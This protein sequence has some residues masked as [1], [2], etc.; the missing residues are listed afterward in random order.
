MRKLVVAEYVTLDGVMQDPGGVGEIEQGGWHNPYWNDELAGFQRDG[1]FASD[2]L[3][4]GRITYEGFAAAWPS[5]TD[6]EGF[7]DQMNGLPK[8][9]VSTTLE[10]ADWNNSRLITGNVADEVAKLKEQPG[11]DILV[12]GSGALVRTLM[13]HDLVDEYRLMVFPVVV[14]SGKRLFTDG[15]DGGEAALRLVGSTATATGV[16]LL[17]YRPARSDG[18]G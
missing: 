13:A 10:R 9:V 7:A 12:Y 3:L 15:G 1:L 14:G 8:Y 16:A 17:T 5:R 6:D 18:E 4:L 11:R 2:A